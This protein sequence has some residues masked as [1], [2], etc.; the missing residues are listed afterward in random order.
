MSIPAQHEKYSDRTRETRFRD[1]VTAR[2]E[3]S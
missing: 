3:A 1:V 2:G